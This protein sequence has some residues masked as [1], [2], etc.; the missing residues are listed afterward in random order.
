M[1]LRK[2]IINNIAIVLFVTMAV[3]MACS[4]EPKNKSVKINDSIEEALIN[5]NKHVLK[6]EDRQ[7]IDYLARYNIAA[8]K[9]ATGV[10]YLIYQKGNGTQI[11]K[12]H[13]VTIKYTLKSLAGDVLY[14][15]DKQGNKTFKM[16]KGEVEAGLE[17]VL[18]LMKNGEKAKVVIPS[19]MAWGLTGDGDKIPPKATLVYD[20]EIINSI[21]N[22]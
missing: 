11:T 14:S 17:E 4:Q 1:P 22:K 9:T 8:E 19:Y 13:V 7:I 10:R 18:L 3:I 2:K 16:G 20:L 12:D 5:A 6:T 15:S 21:I